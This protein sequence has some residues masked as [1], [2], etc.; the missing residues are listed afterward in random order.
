MN[1]LNHKEDILFGKKSRHAIPNVTRRNIHVKYHITVSGTIE[2][3]SDGKLFY[4][5]SMK[6]LTLFFR[7]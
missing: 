3:Y 1:I 4:F 5:Y 6:I 2:S 7:L